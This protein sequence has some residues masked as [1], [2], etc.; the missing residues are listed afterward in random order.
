MNFYLY[1]YAVAWV[2]M[3][4]THAS[5]LG[6]RRS[7]RSP[8]NHSY[9]NVCAGTKTKVLCRGIKFSLYVKLFLL[10]RF[11]Y[12]N[13]KFQ[14]RFICIYVYVYYCT[15]VSVCHM[16]LG[17]RR[18]LKMQSGY[19]ELELHIV[20]R[21]LT[22]VL[23]TNLGYSGRAGSALIYWAVLTAPHYWLIL[24]L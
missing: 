15:H 10:P 13:F 4:H 2:Y 5:A 17:T 16:C 11:I 7:I 8:W 6:A 20:V 1:M 19:L 3:Y 24:L 9:I 23:G 12:F 21:H 18:G 22:W 14:I